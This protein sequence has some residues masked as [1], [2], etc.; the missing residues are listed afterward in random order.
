M[1]GL[2]ELA[3]D[4]GASD[5][6][7]A[8]GRPPD[9][10]DRRCP[11]AAGRPAPVV[12]RHAPAAPVDPQHTAAHPARA[13]PGARLRDRPRERSALPGQRVLPVRRDGRVT[14]RH[15]DEHPR[16]RARSGIPP[17]VLSLVNRAHGLLLVVGPTG[18]GKTTTIA[19]LLE[20]INRA[21]AC[22][23]I[24]VEDPIEYTYHAEA[25]DHRPARAA[26]RY[27]QLRERAAPRTPSGPRRDLRGRDARSRDHGSGDLRGG[28]RPPRRWP[29]RT[30]TTRSRR[31]TAS[32]TSST[33]TSRCR[34]GRSWRIPCSV[35]RLPA[36]AAAG[37]T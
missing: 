8:V 15:P 37:R 12:D 36:A 10:A 27:A 32:S 7:I 28:D 17:I 19:C 14:A 30:P 9:P 29:P 5:I 18:A 1:T 22:R 16:T 6:H 3:V 21:R 2:L 25:R 13:R 23:I 4:K 31:S 20:Q 34:C 35:N 24:T 33:P 11:A 26:R